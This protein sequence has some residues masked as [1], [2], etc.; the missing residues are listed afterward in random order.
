MDGRKHRP[1]VL[2]PSLAG[3][4]SAGAV[5]VALAGKVRALLAA[6]LTPLSSLFSVGMKLCTLRAA[7]LRPEAP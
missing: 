7:P 4:D 3:C 5:A 6:V 2:V 1:I